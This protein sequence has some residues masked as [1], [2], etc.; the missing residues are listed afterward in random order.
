[1]ALFV[2]VYTKAY[3]KPFDAANLEEAG[4]KA[5]AEMGEDHGKV[6]LAVRTGA[7]HQAALS[8]GEVG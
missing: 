2:M 7:E 5:K 3:S 1:M 4:R 8:R 6:L